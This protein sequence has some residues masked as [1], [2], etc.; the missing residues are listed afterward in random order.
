[1]WHGLKSSFQSLLSKHL[2]VVVVFVAWLAIVLTNT[3]LGTWFLS[4]D[5]MASEFNPALNIERSIT[6]AW[7]SFQGLGLLGGHGYSAQLFH[8]VTQAVLGLFI[9]LQYLRY[10]FMYLMLLVG[11]LG[12]YVLTAQTL[13]QLN[14]KQNTKSWAA[15]IG[16]LLYLL[17]PGTVQTF[18]VALEPFAVMYGVLPWVLWSFVGLLENRTTR[19]LVVFFLLNLY[20]SIIGFI[21]P[22]FITYGL[23]L[24]CAASTAFFIHPK[25]WETVR[26]SL[27]AVLIVLATNA[28]WLAPVAY[29]TATQGDHYLFA[30][31]NQIT[32]TEF[33]YTTRATGNLAEVSLLEGFLFDSYDQARFDS[34]SPLELI[35]TPWKQ[36]LESP[37]VRMIG[38]S[39]ALLSLW[40]VGWGAVRLSKRSATATGLAIAAV[41][42]FVLLLTDTWPL[43]YVSDAIRFVPI[44]NQAFRI[45]YSKLSMSASLFLSLWAA[46]GISGLF[47]LFSRRLTQQTIARARNTTGIVCVL[48]VLWLSWPSMQGHFLYQGARVKLPEEYTEVMEYFAKRPRYGRVAVFP[49]YTYTG[50]DMHSWMEHRGYTGSGFLWYG[51]HQP[52]LGRSFDVWSPFNETYRLEMQRA[53]YNQDVDQLDR[54]LQ[55]YNIAHV[56]LDDSVYLPNTN[57]EVFFVAELQAMLAMLPGVEKVGTLGSISLYQNKSVAVAPVSAVQSATYTTANSL[58]S[59]F[60][61]STLLTTDTITADETIPHTIYPFAN[62]QQESIPITNTSNGPSFVAHETLSGQYELTFPPLTQG[63]YLSQTAK[64][65]YSDAELKIAFSTPLRVLAGDTSIEFPTL[66][67][68]AVPL[69]VSPEALTIEL[70]G[71]VIELKANSE[72]AVSLTGLRYGEEITIN[73]FDTAIATPSA[74]HILIESSDLHTAT[75]P[76]AIWNELQ[77]PTTS[78]RLDQ[79]Q[80]TLVLTTIASSNLL[81][82][83]HI[84]KFASCTEFDRG[85]RNKT[86]TANSVLYENS[87]GATGCDSFIIPHANNQTPALLRITGKNHAGRNIRAYLENL[88]TNRVDFEHVMTSK[89]FDMWVTVPDWKNQ[90]ISQYSL[91]FEN[92]S[93]GTE[94]A[95]NELNAISIQPMPASFE[96]LSQVALIP[97]NTQLYSTNLAV[98]TIKRWGTGTYWV[99]LNGENGV[100]SLN[101]SRNPGWRAYVWDGTSVWSALQSVLKHQQIKAEVTV[102]NWA[103]GW[104]IPEGVTTIIVIH[105]AQILLFIGIWI[106]LVCSFLV[107]TGLLQRQKTPKSNSPAT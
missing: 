72:Q 25:R 30:K 79:D 94:L 74:T 5:T 50:W 81:D 58:Y 39:I 15:T 27:L 103:Q 61:P 31:L 92:R 99:E 73:Y 80:P 77:L 68:V 55:K 40:G 57:K 76:S 97:K 102:N 65:A 59:R 35:L 28:Y 7:Q 75:I 60:D 8:A 20:L 46:V 9:P 14:L 85:S 6:G 107:A 23:F 42:T 36:H 24:G 66:P 93:Y 56:L 18:Y 98:N 34:G 1:M 2:G 22:L 51:M 83:L 3:E 71:Q 11:V 48:C 82:S 100:M 44:L 88:A 17:H 29:F 104:F 13:E 69:A 101:E 41:C 10:A 62:L 49:I 90:A 16:A 38:Y 32:T 95:Q 64:L 4:W 53:V 91:H 47:E 106:L 26:T 54:L 84:T 67:S 21:P 86:M 96:W 43:T 12:A 70:N 37:V 89:E 105:D 63:Q 78:V 19:K 33:I 87:G 45:P 52:I